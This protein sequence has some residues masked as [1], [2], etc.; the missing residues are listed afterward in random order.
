MTGYASYVTIDAMK[1][2]MLAGESDA[3]LRPRLLR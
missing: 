1:Q 3:S 2:G